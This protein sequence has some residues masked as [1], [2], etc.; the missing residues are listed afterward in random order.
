MPGT[1]SAARRAVGFPLTQYVEE[2]VA[3]MVNKLRAFAPE[4]M[5]AASV[6]GGA[7]RELPLEV[8]RDALDD[9]ARKRVDD[10][11]DVAEEDKLKGGE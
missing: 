10:A 9:A 2:G 1:D 7:L 8:L 3:L 6:I 11:I 4:T 5:L